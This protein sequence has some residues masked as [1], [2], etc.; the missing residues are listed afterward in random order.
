MLS[1]YIPVYWPETNSWSFP[2]YELEKYKDY[3][4]EPQDIVLYKG[5]VVKG[6]PLLHFGTW[7]AMGVNITKTIQDLAKDPGK[8][9]QA[10]FRSKKVATK[11]AAFFTELKKR[12][13]DIVDVKPFDAETNDSELNVPKD[14]VVILKTD[15]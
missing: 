6:I 15:D 14:C 3:V 7:G 5:S 1:D 10:C 11:T 4:P 12:Y 8:K 2:S 13:P 9:A